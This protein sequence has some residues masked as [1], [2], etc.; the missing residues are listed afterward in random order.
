MIYWFLLIATLA[1]LTLIVLRRLRLTYQ[2]LRFQKNLQEEEA[3]EAALNGE[4]PTPEEALAEESPS[5]PKEGVRK[6][7]LKAD[8]HF[9]RN[10]WK[11][12]EALFLTVLELDEAHLDA[13]HKLGLL[14]M[15]QD[16][17]PQAE[18]FF[19]KLVNLK[20]DPVYFSNLGAALYQQQRLVEAAE[21]YEQALALDDR[22]AARLQSLAQV[23][24]ELGEDEK[25][26]HYFERAARRKPKDIGLKFILADY[27][28][29]LE[30]Y[31]SAL[32]QLKKLAELDPY[33][34]EV[35]QRIQE[36]QSRLDS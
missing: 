4:P 26:L 29:R 33:N 28:E 36:L 14:Y 17:F 16:D 19:S 15:K 18:L 20:K 25:A 2:D 11:E 32:E 22:R 9:A 7:F 5:V 8:A 10:E 34:E 12:A 6:S 35:N 24:F 30:R 23:Y 31:E 21:A 27:Y 13:H 3:V 1:L